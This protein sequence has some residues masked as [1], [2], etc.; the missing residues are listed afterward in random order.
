MKL[1]TVYLAFNTAN[2]KTYV[3]KTAGDL[4]ARWWRH[5]YCALKGQKRLFRF[6][7]AIRKYGP[8]SFV[9]SVLTQCRTNDEACVAEGYWITFFNSTDPCQ[10][11]NM[12]LGGEGTHG[13][14]QR[15]SSETRA[16]MSASH[17]GKR[18]SAEHRRKLS[19]SNKGKHSDMGYRHPWAGGTVPAEIRE[20]ISKA[21]LG[22]CAGTKNPMHGKTHSE[23]TRE[24]IRASQTII[25][26]Q[27]ALELLRLHRAGETKVTL[28]QRAGVSW[29]TMANTLKRAAHLAAETPV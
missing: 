25:N 22:R 17:K 29:G 7:H 11:Y 20:K 28:A 19:E 2:G 21:L 6:Q 8:E 3:G 14:H 12:T 16:R 15:L 26:D 1:H 27:D 13:F 5:C 10:G 18:F 23:Q 9:L 24:K 4:S